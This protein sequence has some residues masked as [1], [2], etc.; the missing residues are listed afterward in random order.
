[1]VEGPPPPTRVYDIIGTVGGNLEVGGR[2]EAVVKRP[3][4]YGIL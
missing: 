4:R 3:T 1:M 2:V